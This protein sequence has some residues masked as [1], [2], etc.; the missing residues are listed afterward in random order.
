M[1][2]PAVCTTATGPKRFTLTEVAKHNRK[3]DGWIAVD[4]KVCGGRCAALL[5]R[6]HDTVC[7]RCMTLASLSPRTWAGNARVASLQC[8]PFCAA[9]APSALRSFGAFTQKQRMRSLL[10]FTLATLTMVARTV[11]FVAIH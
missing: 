3:E 6:V 7:H 1:G 9:W 5:I 4:G 8:L 11:D 10:H 2:L